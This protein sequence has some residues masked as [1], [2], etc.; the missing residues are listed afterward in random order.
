MSGRATGCLPV[1][2]HQYWNNVTRFKWT[3][4]VVSGLLLPF[5]AINT[6]LER[7]TQARH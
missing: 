6:E 5:T 7:Q 1:F 2:V 4:L 3:I